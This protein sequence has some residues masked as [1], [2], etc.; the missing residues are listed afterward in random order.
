[1]HNMH[2]N[3]HKMYAIFG[4]I[5]NLFCFNE[6][7]VQCAISICLYLYLYTFKKVSVYFNVLYFMRKNVLREWKS[8]PWVWKTY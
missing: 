7:G 2:I 3:F 8:S 6:K 5:I 4:H 1:M